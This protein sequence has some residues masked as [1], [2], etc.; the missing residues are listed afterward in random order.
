MVGATSSPSHPKHSPRA[1]IDLRTFEQDPER[2]RLANLPS[3]APAQSPW[4][5]LDLFTEEMMRRAVSEEYGTATRA[6]MEWWQEK[7]RG[8]PFEVV[9]LLTFTGPSTR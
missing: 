9:T 6:R 5:A 8:R 2:F 3:A 4:K 1:L 7:L